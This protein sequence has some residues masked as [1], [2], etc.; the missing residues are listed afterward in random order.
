M[1]A[2]YNCSSHFH[3]NYLPTH[4]HEGYACVGSQLESI[5]EEK[6]WASR[7]F[8]LHYICSSEEAEWQMLEVRSLS[9]WYL[10]PVSVRSTPRVHLKTPVTPFLKWPETH[11]TMS[12]KWVQ[13]LSNWQSIVSKS[14]GKRV[15]SAAW[16]TTPELRRDM[17][18]NWRENSI[19]SLAGEWTAH[20]W[21]SC[22]LRLGLTN[23]LC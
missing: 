15:S 7:A 22:D 1:I 14:S 16:M 13:I 11:K 19:S 4:L 21:S 8:R 3:G 12:P 23:Y 17:R 9:A 5:T 10:T 6:T 20:G 18:D 2:R